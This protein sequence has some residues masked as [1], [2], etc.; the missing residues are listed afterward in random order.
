MSEALQEHRRRQAKR[1]IK[2]VEVTISASDAELIRRVAKALAADD[3]QSDRVRAVLQGHVAR[4]TSVKF[5]DW[6]ATLSDDD[7]K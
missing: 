1:G 3:D 4:A 2:R 6:L 7:V 5:K